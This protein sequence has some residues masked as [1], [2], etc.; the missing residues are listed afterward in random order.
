[1]NSPH[2]EQSGQLHVG[3][4]TEWM[5]ESINSLTSD[6]F[7]AADCSREAR[8]HLSDPRIVHAKRM[9]IYQT[10]EL[11]TRSAWPSVR[12]ANR[13]CEAHGRLSGPRTVHANR[14]AIY[15]ACELFTRTAWTLRKPDSLS[16]EWHEERARSTNFNHGFVRSEKSGLL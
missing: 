5:L 6:L 7:K 16:R 2:G 10:R 4:T 14:M 12:P 15:Q 8:G 11:F 13:S 9:A 3:F 1:M